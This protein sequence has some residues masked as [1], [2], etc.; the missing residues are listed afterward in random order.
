MICISCL[1]MQKKCPVESQKKNSGRWL[2]GADV[3]NDMFAYKLKLKTPSLTSS[4]K[5]PES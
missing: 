5:P 2:S 1:F 4:F 3:F